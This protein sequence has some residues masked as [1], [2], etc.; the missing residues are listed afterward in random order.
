M[1]EGQSQKG[2]LINP[3]RTVFSKNIKTLVRLE[4]FTCTYSHF[5]QVKHS[6]GTKVTTSLVYLLAR[7][8]GHLRQLFTAR[9]LSFVA[10]F[11]SHS[12]L[13]PRDVER[14]TRST[15][16]TNRKQRE[17]RKRE[18]ERETRFLSGYSNQSLLA[19]TTMIPSN[20]IQSDMTRPITT[21][22]YCS[23]RAWSQEISILITIAAHYPGRVLVILRVVIVEMREKGRIYSY[24]TAIF[25]GPEKKRKEKK[26][27]HTW[28]TKFPTRIVKQFFIPLF[29]FKHFTQHLECATLSSS[30]SHDHTMITPSWLT[31]SKLNRRTKDC[32]YRELFQ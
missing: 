23:R 24:V 14:S 18:R 5:H 32:F 31:P 2:R 1:E 4:K 16:R 7:I 20:P 12:K 9:D 19:D 22:R 13:N 28:D 29:L 10:Y 27:Q 11:F 3:R 8:T 21:D 30:Y 6:S 26:N 17:A 25:T 15:G